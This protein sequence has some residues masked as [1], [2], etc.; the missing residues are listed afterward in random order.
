MSTKHTPGPWQLDHRGY[1]FIVAAPKHGYI[2]RDVCRM[3]ASTMSAFHRE[4]N[5]RLIAAAPDLLTA[6]EEVL[7]HVEFSHRQFK[8]E[9]DAAR[10]A[11]A[12]ATGQ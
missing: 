6:L 4:A 3:D 2:T 11:I 9:V 7:P 8:A 12:K 5:A 10:A 1:T